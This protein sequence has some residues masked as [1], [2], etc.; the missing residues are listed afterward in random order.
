MSK[1]FQIHEEDLALLE[2]QLPAILEATMQSCNDAMLRKRW[3]AVRDVVSRVR[4][5]YGPPTS[6]ETVDE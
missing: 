6:V 4:W 2:Q 3:E 5:N 1:L